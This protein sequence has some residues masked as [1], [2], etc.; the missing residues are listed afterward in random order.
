[1][2][3]ILQILL[4]SIG[5]IGCSSLEIETVSS[6]AKQ[7]QQILALGLTHDANLIEA[8]KLKSSHMIA[9][10]TSQLNKA[11]DEKIQA[12]FDLLESTKFAEMVVVSNNNSNF[13]GSK[14]SSSKVRG[15]LGDN[16][17]Q[18][19]YLSGIKNINNNFLN[20]KLNLIITYN[21]ES[22]RNYFSANFCDKWQGCDDQSEESINL[23]SASASGCNGT[24]C[25]YKEIMELDIP[26][27]F[28]RDIMEE[29]I[30]VSFNSKKLTNKITISSAYIKGY[31]KIAK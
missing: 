4:L 20:H 6:S 19:Y 2:K 29:G 15:I 1:M 14:I 26:D 30:S 27:Y 23:I 13:I 28:L 18:E 7:A 11:R 31:L 24:S 8:G 12:D 16:D 9:V 21:S 5:L 25:I 3:K 22:K 17:L 10:V